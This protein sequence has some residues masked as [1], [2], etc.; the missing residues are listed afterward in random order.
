ML[1][2]Q[3]SFT[4][5]FTRISLPFVLESVQGYFTA[6]LYKPVF[7]YCFIKHDR[8]DMEKNISNSVRFFNVVFMSHLIT[9]LSWSSWSYYEFM[10]PE[11]VRWNSWSC[12]IFILLAVVNLVIFILIAEVKTLFWNMFL[13]D[14][15]WWKINIIHTKIHFNVLFGMHCDDKSK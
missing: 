2:F 9:I 8:A 7:L 4:H 13:V 6:H 5:F 11:V 15:I 3:L 1:H 10:L 14:F 12:H